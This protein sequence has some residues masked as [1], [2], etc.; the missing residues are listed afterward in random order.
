MLRSTYYV[1]ATVLLFGVCHQ[2]STYQP[3]VDK[4]STVVIADG[5]APPP[6]LPPLAVP[7]AEMQLADGPAPPPPLPPL[8]VPAAE[9]QLADGPA[10]PP[11]LPPLALP[12][13]PVSPV[14]A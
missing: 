10:P 4:H 8:A 14:Q 2:T 9:M 1:L 12:A 6:P 5:P 11:P 13:F 7:T 3:A